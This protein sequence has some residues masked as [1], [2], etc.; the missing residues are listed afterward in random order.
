MK[1]LTPLFIV[2]LL[3]LTGC[4]TKKK[5]EEPPKVSAASEPEPLFRHVESPN[6]TT[7]PITPKPKDIFKSEK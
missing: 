2:S 7:L 1:Q 6:D 5:Q 4:N 3:T